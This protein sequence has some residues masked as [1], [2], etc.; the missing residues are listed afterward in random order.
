MIR[1]TAT[2]EY[3]SGMSPERRY[4]AKCPTCGFRAEATGDYA[5]AIGQARHH[6]DTAQP[7]DVDA[8]T[9]AQAD[10]DGAC[11][12]RH[13]NAWIGGLE[14]VDRGAEARRRLDAALSALA[15]MDTLTNRTPIEPAPIRDLGD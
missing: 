12:E 1:H 2:V 11:M 7:L 14:G 15:R 9:Q 4:V 13:W 3:L 10:E 8:P 6:N 5:E